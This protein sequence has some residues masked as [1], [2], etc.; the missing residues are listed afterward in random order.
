[1][2]KTYRNVVHLRGSPTNQFFYDLSFIYSNDILSPP[3]WKQTFITIDPK[4][5]IIFQV[6]ANQLAKKLKLQI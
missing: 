2:K 4:K 6:K 1:M 5:I 3:N